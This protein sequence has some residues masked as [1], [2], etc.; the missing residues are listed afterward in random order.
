[1]KRA[2]ILAVILTMIAGAQQIR[3]TYDKNGRIT[4]AD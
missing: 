3:Y 2:A 1:M 4:K